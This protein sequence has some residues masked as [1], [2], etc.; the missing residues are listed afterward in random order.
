MTVFRE[1]WSGDE[2]ETLIN[3]VVDFFKINHALHSHI[4]IQNSSS[5]II[6]DDIQTIAVIDT[7][8]S[9]LFLQNV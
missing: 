5:G 2:K 1:F 4:F 3:F 6:F 9:V 8:S 7:Y